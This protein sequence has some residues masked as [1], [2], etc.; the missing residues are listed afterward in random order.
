MSLRQCTHSRNDSPVK[1]LE[2]VAVV[3]RRIGW[4]ASRR[5][6]GA[7][8]DNRELLARWH[9]PRKPK[10]RRRRAVGAGGARNG[11]RGDRGQGDEYE[12]CGAGVKK[13]PRPIENQIQQGAFTRSA[14][15]RAA[16]FMGENPVTDNRWELAVVTLVAIAVFFSVWHLVAPLI[17]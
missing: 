4:W 17:G 9:L 12:G 8:P 16:P 7:V 2:T 1:G 10:C 11:R 13:S 3:S 6:S 14:P 5:S 15:R